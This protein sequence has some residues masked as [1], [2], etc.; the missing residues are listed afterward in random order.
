MFIYLE[1]KFDVKSA[2]S[3][4]LTTVHPG[5]DSEDAVKKETLK[6]YEPVGM[7]PKRLLEEFYGTMAPVRRVHYKERIA[8]LE[9]L[10]ANPRTSRDLVGLIRKNKA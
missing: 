10:V 2:I 3:N 8:H 7:S 6:A 1:D 5:Y 9:T 4:G